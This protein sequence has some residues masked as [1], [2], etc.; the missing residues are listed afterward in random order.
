MSRLNHLLDTRPGK[1]LLWCYGIGVAGFYA[2]LFWRTGVAGTRDDATAECAAPRGARTAW[3]AVTIVVPARDEERNIRDCVASL[4]EQ[5]YPRFDVLVVD[6][7]SS[8]ATPAILADLQRS[9]RHGDRLRV[10]RVA[11]LPVGWAGK[12]HALHVGASAASGAW[13]LFTDA[14]TRHA[15]GAL[16]TAVCIAEERGLDLLSYGT[17]QDLPDFWG[18]V[19]MP[20]A[21]MGISMMYAPNAVNDPRSPVAIANGQIILIR[22]ATYQ[23]LGGYATPALRATVVDDRDLAVAVKRATGKLALVDGRR[24]VT[25]RMY[26]GLREHVDGWSKNAYVGSRG[27]LLFYLTMIAGL[28]VTTIGPFALLLHGLAYRNRTATAAGALSTAALLAYRARLDGE[29]GVPRRY[30]LTHPLAGAVFS[31][32]LVRSLWRKLSGRGVIWRGRTIRV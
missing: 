10:E 6:D 32:I 18:R 12:P 31:G 26:H 30:G 20:M 5:D 28:P 1:L 9:H 7:A 8:D 13:L 17:R 29:L 14:D 22:R 23:A 16:R 25:T 21:Y 2:A 24:L 19:L 3:P 27:G 11:A 4:L 15:P